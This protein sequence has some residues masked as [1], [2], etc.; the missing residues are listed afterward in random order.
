MMQ[1]YILGID[2]GLDGGLF[3]FDLKI[4]QHELSKMPISIIKPK[5]RRQINATKI[6]KMLGP[7]RKDISMAIVE[8]VNAYPGQGIVSM[9]NF[10]YGFG[11]IDGVLSTLNIKT[12]KAHPATWKSAI[13]L[14]ADKASSLAMAKKLFP[15]NFISH[16]GIAE[17]A[18]L[19][20][21]AKEYYF[22]A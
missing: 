21:F 14:D 16:D 6:A 7:I 11:Q 19:T 17:A 1:R 13:G 22:K 12:I 4:G 18:L 3:L 2:P 15:K 9:F 10:G 8:Q 5:N 20:H